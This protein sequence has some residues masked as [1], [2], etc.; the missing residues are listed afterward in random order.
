LRMRKMMPI[1]A[2]WLV[3]SLWVAGLFLL[4]YWPEHPHSTLGWS[5]LILGALPLSA[6]A[7]ILGDRL[8][9]RSE[10]GARLNALGSGLVPSLLRILYVLVLFL[11]LAAVASLLVTALNRTGWLSAL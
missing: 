5:L 3:L 11:S 10:L 7:E 6:L 9:F 1:V 2:T 8:I 4:S